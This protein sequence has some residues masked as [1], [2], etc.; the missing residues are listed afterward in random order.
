MSQGVGLQA[1]SK[2][3][4]DSRAILEYI[5]AVRKA[6]GLSTLVQLDVEGVP[7]SKD[8]C[9]VALWTRCRVV[10]DSLL[11]C[12]RDEAEVV[13]AAT[14]GTRLSRESGEDQ[15]VYFDETCIC[16]AMYLPQPLVLL[17][18]EFDAG[19]LAPDQLCPV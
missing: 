3:T 6:R 5:N 2:S 7:E 4:Y 17:I 19:E 16:W 13:S 8:E 14:R 15:R 10:S 12:S 1:H 18:A 9:T 11:F